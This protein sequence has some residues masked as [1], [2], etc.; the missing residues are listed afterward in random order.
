MIINILAKSNQFWQV[1][2]LYFKTHAQKKLPKH[3]L[4]PWFTCNKEKKLCSQQWLC[5]PWLFPG[6]PGT[7]V[8]PSWGPTPEGHPEV[9]LA[10]RA[11]LDILQFNSVPG[12]LCLTF[13][14]A[15]FLE[16]EHKASFSQTSF[17][18]GFQ[19]PWF[20]N[21]F[22]SLKLLRIQNV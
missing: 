19:S 2:L 21:P 11:A 18:S 3:F 9:S 16:S 22:H 4:T 13:L 20:Q 1:S 15:G 6:N 8:V 17:H 12:M 7:G 5:L 14:P 10:L